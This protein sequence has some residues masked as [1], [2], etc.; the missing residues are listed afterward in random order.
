M[1]NEIKVARH[2][3]LKLFLLALLLFPGIASFSAS[4]GY[5]LTNCPIQGVTKTEQSTGSVSYSWSPV[6]GASA[7]KVYFVRLSDNYTSSVFTTGSTSVTFSGLPAGGY[8]FYF[9]AVCGQE[10]LEYILDD[11]LML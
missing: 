4:P 10:G 11:V 1:K 6:S 8:R 5:S 7:Y 2:A 3:G 9:A